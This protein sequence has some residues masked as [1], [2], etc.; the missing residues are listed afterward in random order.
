MNLARQHPG[1]VT[2]RRRMSRTTGGF[3]TALA[4]IGVYL[5]VPSAKPPAAAQ[6][7]SAQKTRAV[8]VGVIPER[9]FVERDE[10]GQYLNCDF[11]VE[12]QTGEKI[13][14]RRIE[15]STFDA[16][17]RISSRR[18]LSERGSLSPALRTLPRREIESDAVVDIFNPFHTLDPVE[19]AATVRFA[20]QFQGSQQY[21]AAVAIQPVLY[22]PKTKL[23]VPLRGPFLV[24]DGHDYYS[25]HRRIDLSSPAIKRLGLTF[26]PVRYA[27]DFSPVD[28]TRS[29]H[30][31]DPGKPENW[32]AYNAPLHAPAAGRVVS[33]ANDVPDNRIE[34]GRLVY[35]ESA[36]D[37]VKSRLF[38]NHVLIDHGVGE[39]SL[40]AHLKAKTVAAGLDDRS[41]AI[42]VEQR[43]G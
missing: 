37:D 21:D 1:D 19:P 28:E 31:G 13:R 29:L 18:F 2:Q 36:N 33:V 12:N 43:S 16:A 26:N 40:L 35:P 4:A 7:P 17:N 20:F 30:Q 11:R 8:R 42:C 39:Y 34:S 24:Y 15:V 23:V 14:L 10:K 27:Y 3:L 41:L 38:G 25:H 22:R 9:P 32:I 6:G 5:L